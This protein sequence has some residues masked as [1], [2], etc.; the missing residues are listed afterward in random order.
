MKILPIFIWIYFAMIATSFWEAYVEGR[1]PWDK[2]KL[3]WKLRF[4]GKTILTAYHFWLFIV[5]YPMLLSLPFVIYGFDRKLFGVIVSAYFSGLVIED[6]FWFVVNPV[7]KLEN[8]DSKHVKWF[9]W[10]RMGRFEVPVNYIISLG[11]AF[12]SWC[13]LWY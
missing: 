5:M 9:H 13:F 2:G 1:R 7:F 3:G 10:I 12:L 4:K 6:I 8:W 11:L